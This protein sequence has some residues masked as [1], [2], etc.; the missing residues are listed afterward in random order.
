MTDDNPGSPIP[1]VILD[2]VKRGLREL[3]TNDLK[4]AKTLVI[5]I[6]DQEL[7]FRGRGGEIVD[8]QPA[9]QS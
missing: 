6:I 1:P 2:T 9:S 3:D 8:V 4:L 5:G 7:A